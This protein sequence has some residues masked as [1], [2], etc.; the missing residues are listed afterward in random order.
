MALLCVLGASAQPFMPGTGFAPLG[1]PRPYPVSLTLSSYRHLGLIML[2][3]GLFSK[4]DE[5][6]CMH[7]S[8][9]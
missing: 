7:V 9:I 2:Y 3:V 4:W 6:R 8:A 1:K 5:W